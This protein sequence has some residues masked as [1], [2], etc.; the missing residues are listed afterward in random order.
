MMEA[1]SLEET[2]AA[3]KELKTAKELS[4]MLVNMSKAAP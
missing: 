1:M 2:V 3:D 4:S